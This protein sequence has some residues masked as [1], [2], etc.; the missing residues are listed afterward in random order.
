MKTSRGK[1]QI[2]MEMAYRYT[3]ENQEDIGEIFDV[4]YS[5]VSQNRERLRA[6]LG[7]DLTLQKAFKEMGKILDELSK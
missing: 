6:K 3:H 2:V 7:K 5:T 4:D 1:R